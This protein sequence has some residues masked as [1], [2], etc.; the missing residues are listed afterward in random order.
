MLLSVL[1]GFVTVIVTTFTKNWLEDRRLERTLRRQFNPST[2]QHRDD[3][4]LSN[5]QTSAD[6]D[7]EHSADNGQS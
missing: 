2:S 7:L 4:D 5:P 1:S 6:L 3:T